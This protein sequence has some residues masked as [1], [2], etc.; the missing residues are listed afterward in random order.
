MSQTQITRAIPFGRPNITD[1][2]R[3]AVL[4][5][6]QGHI[7][8][9]GPQCTAFESEFADFMGADANCVSVSS[10]M[11]ALHLAYLHFGVGA[12][13]EVIVPAMT[14]V[15]TVHAVEW[16]GATPVFID[17]DPAT[18]NVTPEAV[19]AAVT[20]RTKAVSVVHFQGIPCDMPGIME[21]ANRHDLKV[22]EDCALAVGGRWDG[23]H[24]GLFGDAA[25]F[26]FYPV[27]HLTSGEGGM[28]ATRHPDVAKAVARKR[29]FGVDRR[30]DQR[31]TPGMYDVV[32]LGLNYRMSE[33]QAALGRSQ[34]RRI[35]D[36]LARRAQNFRQIKTGLSVLP[37]TRVLD[38]T[39]STAQNAHYG[40]TLV[41]EGALKPHRNRIISRLNEQEIG[42]SVYYPQPVPRMT[43][44][45]ER[46]GYDASGYTTAAEIADE[47]IALPVGP[48]VDSEDAATIVNQVRIVLTEIANEQRR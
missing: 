15:A 32:E 36:A 19:A 5:V 35:D 42:T 33:M 18:G 17:C 10:G 45:R 26:S 11:A 8:T 3:Q 38:T 44:Y 37:D 28:F 24:V 9:H 1:E 29:A 13:D 7:L 23:R 31:T 21:V 20:P 47:S 6:L 16:S 34:L 25:C 41:L 27:K 40:L 4:E 46:Y 12:G 39:S 48:H 43:Y 22:I 30:H 14:H 2:D